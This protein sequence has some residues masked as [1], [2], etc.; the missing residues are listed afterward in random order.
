VDSS[1]TG[2]ATNLRVMSDSSLNRRRLLVLGGSAFG[3]AALAAGKAGATLTLRLTVADYTANCAPL[4]NAAVEIW[5]C[6]AWGYY[7][8]DTT[9]NPGG[10]APPEDGAGDENT[11]LRGILITDESGVVEF[12]TISRA[13]TPRAVHVHCKVYTG[14]AV[15]SGTDTYEGGTAHHTG[16]FVFPEE[17]VSQVETVAPYSQHTGTITVADDMVYTGG[18]DGLLSVSGSIASAAETTTTTN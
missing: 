2:T 10:S 16:Q 6:D 9:A 11:Y 18:R 5:H 17:L 7:S 12:T 1:L 4:A 14:G 8:G 13:G 15:D 3:A